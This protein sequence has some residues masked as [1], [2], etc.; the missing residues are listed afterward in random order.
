[1]LTFLLSG[2]HQHRYNHI[3][4]PGNLSSANL[5]Q[6]LRQSREICRSA[7]VSGGLRGVNPTDGTIRVTVQGFS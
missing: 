4:E 1:M 3:H 7:G 6:S 2:A 5:L